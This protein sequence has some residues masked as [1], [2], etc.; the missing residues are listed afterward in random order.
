MEKTR[1]TI[2]P[3]IQ[4]KGELIGK[5]DLAI[6]GRVEGQIKL[7]DNELV[8]G[9]KARIDATLEAKT[10]RVEGEVKGDLI[11]TD[12]VELANGSTV[13]GDIISPRIAIADGAR[14]KGSVDM[15]RSRASSSP[16]RPAHAAMGGEK[17][18]TGTPAS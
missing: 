7:S 15:D 10:I 5:E 2:G 14:F 3:S 11:A 17:K 4:I 18:P 13:T 9:Q 6:E 1:A 12:R 16:A 8:I